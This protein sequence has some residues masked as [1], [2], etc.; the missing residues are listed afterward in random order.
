MNTVRSRIKYLFF[1]LIPLLVLCVVM[2][3]GLRAVYYQ[4]RGGYPLALIHGYDRLQQVLL[5]KRAERR[6]TAL[7][8]EIGLAEEGAIKVHEIQGKIERKFFSDAG[9]E[10]FEYVKQQYENIFVEFVQEVE[11]G[12]AKLL[13]LHI[14]G[15][16]ES[17][18]TKRSLEFFLKL[19]KKHDIDFI[20]P[21]QTLFR[22]LP[23][24]I[25]L[26]PQDTHLSRFGNK[27]LVEQLSAAI[28]KYRNYKTE[29]HF[30]ERSSLFGP[31]KPKTDS[32]WT[33]K[34]SM[35]FRVITNKQGLRMTYDI[36]FPKTKQRILVLGD[37][38][39]FAPF[40]DNHDAYP[41][42]LDREYSDKEVLNAGY[43]G[44][45]ITD[46]LSLFRERAKF[47]E[48]DIVILQVCPNDL[49]DLLFF[50]R[51]LNNYFE[52]EPVL[53]SEVEIQFLKTLQTNTP[54]VSKKRT[55][56]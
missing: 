55:Q 42:L 29:W 4:R 2:E 48:P 20:D 37:S 24:Q 3:C 19:S 31:L 18:Q 40:L 45:T 21:S 25:K 7:F 9:K 28:H 15:T 26:Y 13:V 30:Q 49:L 34:H 38:F 47:V 41:N 32:I 11:G 54:W 27:L 14:P 23:D 50:K 16:A 43:P 8:Q 52:D 22:Y 53:P 44:Y 33:L 39:T 36:T 1:A 12:G 5:Q 51:N 17:I 6:V 10:V 46:E 56:F 35:P